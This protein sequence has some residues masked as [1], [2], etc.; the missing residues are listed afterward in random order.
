M[1]HGFVPANLNLNEII[2]T[3][4]P[5]FKYE[6]E[7]F[8]Y[9]I[10][11]IITLPSYNKGFLEKEFVPIKAQL[12][13][14]RIRTYKLHLDYLI[15]NN[16]IETDNH[17]IPNEK[18]KGFKLNDLYIESELEEIRFTILSL[19]RRLPEEVTK[20]RYVERNYKYLT[21][22]FNSSLQIDVDNATKFLSILRDNELKEG[23]KNTQYRFKSREISIRNFAATNFSYSIDRTA[24]RFHSN[25]TNLKSE[26]R[27][28]L[29]YNGETLC[30]I[31]IKN[32]QP[33]ISTI[34]LTVHSITNPR[35]D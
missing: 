4:P 6:I 8:H 30:S 16:I 12:L 24:Y 27:Q 14:R 31:D 21:R 29:N 1:K 20:Q 25:L 26:L 7:Y 34:F 28:Y 17:Y 18:S 33:F 5:D 11:T 15:E 19:T 2:Q 22:W 9:I 23:I 35:K 10:S 3:N 13:Q 32:S